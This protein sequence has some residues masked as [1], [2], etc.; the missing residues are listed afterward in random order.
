MAN[1]ENYIVVLS[2]MISD[3]RLS[4]NELLV[5]AVIYGY[6]QDGESE[7]FGSLNRLSELLRLDRRTVMRLLQRLLNAG[8][9]RKR[10]VQLN[11]VL[12]SFYCAVA[13]EEVQSL[14]RGGNGEVGAKCPRG[15]NV[16]EVGAKCPGGRGKMPPQY[17]NNNNKII[18]KEKDS[19]SG[20]EKEK[21]SELATPTQNPPP[22]KMFIKPTAA[23]VAAYCEERGNSVDAQ[24]FVNYYESVGWM[25]GPNKPMKD[26]RAAVRTWE[27]RDNNNS[28]GRNNMQQGT[29]RAARLAGAR[30]DIL[31]HIEQAARECNGQSVVGGIFAQ[32]LSCGI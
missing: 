25:V 6:S 20:V 15:Q 22:R 24:R 18:F 1:K 14:D 16:T 2:W 7:Y 13:A 21:A 26:W 28:N 4:G 11:N 30:E 31:A 23:Q 32:E 9:I 10:T 12:R 8:L 27:A 29:G 3:L 5:Y 19:L 17:N